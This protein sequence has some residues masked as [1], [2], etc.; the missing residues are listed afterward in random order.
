MYLSTFVSFGGLEAR[1]GSRDSP[2]SGSPFESVGRRA[3]VL[4]RQPGEVGVPPPLQ[5][6]PP[7]PQVSQAGDATLHA[8]PA[9]RFGVGLVTL[10]LISL[11]TS[12]PLAVGLDA[13]PN[14]LLLALFPGLIALVLYY[15][16][17][18]R[19]CAMQH[20]V[21]AFGEPTPAVASPE[22]PETPEA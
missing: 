20:L 10:L 3:F 13:A 15:L 19:T 4:R 6:G 16:A 7:L 22:T 9:L 21:V 2:G 14:I 12:T 1:R 5:L 17:L 11:V 18:G 8:S